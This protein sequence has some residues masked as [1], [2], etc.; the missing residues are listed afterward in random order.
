MTEAVVW[1][2]SCLTLQ[3]QSESSCQLKDELRDAATWYCIR[4]PAIHVDGQ[5]TLSKEAS[6]QC[7]WAY[8][9]CG[10]LL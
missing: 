7:G 4:D 2:H 9:G 10:V 6:K 8:M 5:Q 3:H 1:W